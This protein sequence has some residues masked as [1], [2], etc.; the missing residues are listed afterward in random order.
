MNPRL[1]K[2]YDPKGAEEKWYAYWEDK[3]YFHADPNP[4]KT[5]YCIT[6]PPPNVTGELHMGH[7]I[8]HAIHDLV[9]RWKRMQ[10]AKTLCLPGTDHAGI[11]TQMK[12]EQQLA[13]DEG[14]SRYD[15]GREALLEKIHAWRDKYGDAIYHQLRKLGSSYDWRRARFTL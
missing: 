4:D 14:L 1:E 12:V 13:A 5:P 9:I 6:I 7:A 8:Q 10:G 11:A 15:V 2:T 3:G